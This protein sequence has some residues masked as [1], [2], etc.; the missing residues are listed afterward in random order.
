MRRRILTALAP[1]LDALAIVLGA[2]IIIGVAFT[3]AAVAGWAV[4]GVALIAGGTLGG[5]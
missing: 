3:F 4:L 2:V 5:K 1:R